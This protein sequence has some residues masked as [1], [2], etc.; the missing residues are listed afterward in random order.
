M[1]ETDT[2]IRLVLATLFGGLVGMERQIHHKPAG[3]RTHIL[4]CIGACMCMIIGLSLNKEF[5]NGIDP[6]RIAAQ[7]VSGIG[8]LG[9]GTIMVSKASVKG[10]TIA[11]SIWATSARL[12]ENS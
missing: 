11:A 12:C 10:L 9:A 4:V 2:L 7:V 3:L 8:F 1:S 6:A 5:G